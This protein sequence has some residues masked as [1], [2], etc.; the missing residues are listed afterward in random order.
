M[1]C[2]R[3]VDLRVCTD[4]ANLASRLS[5]F[6]LPVDAAA[7]GSFDSMRMFLRFGGCLYAQIGVT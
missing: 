5:L 2:S 6:L 7:C 1:A 4:V 3:N